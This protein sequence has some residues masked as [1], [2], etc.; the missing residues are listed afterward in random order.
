M[1]NFKRSSIPHMRTMSIIEQ[2][3]LIARW[4]ARHQLRSLYPEIVTA[5]LQWI[6][7]IDQADIKEFVAK[8]HKGLFG[9][10][11]DDDLAVRLALNGYTP[12]EIEEAILADEAPVNWMTEEE[13]VAVMERIDLMKAYFDAQPSGTFKKACNIY[14]ALGAAVRR[15]FY[16][17]YNYYPEQSPIPHVRIIGDVREQKKLKLSD[18]Q[19]R[20]LEEG[21]DD[22][23]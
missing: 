18:H 21:A 9:A 22:E 3:A 15:N 11:P 16:K 1:P 2:N 23:H 19:P 14:K 10:I 12:E 5:M 8:G 17:R 6:I 20:L 13:E 7:D 4:E